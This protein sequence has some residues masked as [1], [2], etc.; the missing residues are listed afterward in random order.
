[1][2]AMNVSPR[3]INNGNLR[4]SLVHPHAMAVA[5]RI[6]IDKYC[7]SGGADKRVGALRTPGEAREMLGDKTLV[8]KPNIRLIDGPGSSC[9]LLSW[10]R[11]FGFNSSVD[12]S[13]RDLFTMSP[14]LSACT[15][16]ITSQFEVSTHKNENEILFVDSKG[17]KI[18][19]NDFSQ[20]QMAPGGKI[21][22]SPAFI[23]GNRFGL[24]GFQVISHPMNPVAMSGGMENSNA[25]VG[26]LVRAGF[27]LRGADWDAGDLFYAALS[28]ANFC[29]GDN[30]G[31]QG[32]SAML[33]GGWHTFR[34][35]AE[36]G[37]GYIANEA[38]EPELFPNARKYMALVQPGKDFG[39][40]GTRMAAAINDDW[41]GRLLTPEGLQAQR[42]IPKLANI[43]AG[44]IRP[45]LQGDSDALQ[46]VMD[47]VNG[48]KNIRKA[49]TDPSRVYISP[50]FEADCNAVGAASFA[51]GAGGGGEN[52][53]A[54]HVAVGTPA[55][56]Q[57]IIAKYGVVTDA[58]MARVLDPQS[59]NRFLRGVI[60]FPEISEKGYTEEGFAEA[61]I[62]P[63][64]AAPE[65]D[66]PLDQING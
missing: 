58:D 4:V 10:Q 42:E 66:I 50:E 27:G 39:F 61:G 33:S 14:A 53:N 40:Q 22:N 37:F 3:A 43:F 23:L 62:E 1:M 35:V 57:Q 48:Q 17:N 65:F 20:Y 9:D 64:R 60:D 59:G 7:V 24:R 2:A 49:M 28:D 51:L 36:N 5:R 13:I 34:Y 47:T 25:L 11:L 19:A 30:T 21:I 52:D 18:S 54:M 32:L 6:G 41:C 26:G 44:S 55:A 12:P 29:L 8:L 38:V 63:L 56:I 16:G 46:R 45:M 15:S 31:M